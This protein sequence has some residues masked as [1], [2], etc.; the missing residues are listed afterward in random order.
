MN[1]I[2]KA[3]ITI[4]LIIFLFICFYNIFIQQQN[5]KILSNANVAS[6]ENLTKIVSLYSMAP[7]TATRIYA[8]AILY[9]FESIKSKLHFLQKVSLEENYTFC[10]DKRILDLLVPFIFEN[11]KTK[12]N[13]TKEED[14]IFESIKGKF[15][16]SQEKEE[17]VRVNNP[18][19]FS[20]KDN[21]KWFQENF[22][23]Y[24]L[25]CYQKIYCL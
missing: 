16:R 20:G 9:R 25:R 4:L 12:C 3:T 14:Q 21:T 17:F 22:L 2:T 23:E 24:I 6:T 11:D 1:K 15:D 7:T 13:Y 19:D 18:I 8:F 10:A 5:K